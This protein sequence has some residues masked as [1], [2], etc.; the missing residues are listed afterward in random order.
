[1]AVEQHF[2]DKFNG[3]MSH[4]S[5]PGKHATDNDMR[6]LVFGDYM[7]IRDG[8]RLYDEIKNQEVLRVVGTLDQSSNK[9]FTLHLKPSTNAKSG[10]YFISKFWQNYFSFKTKDLINWKQMTDKAKHLWESRQ[11][12]IFFLLL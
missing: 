1:M 9:V 10:W 6:S 2:K 3:L 11:L 8:P 7:G 12:Q 4:L 5:T